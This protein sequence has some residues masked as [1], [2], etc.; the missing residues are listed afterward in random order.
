M[1]AWRIFRR[2]LAM[3][4]LLFSAYSI[5]N[6]AQNLLL[7]WP[8]Y[9]WALIGLVVFFVFSAFEVVSLDIELSSKRP[10][11]KLAREPFVG[12]V[13]RWKTV[14]FSISEKG[15]NTFIEKAVYTYATFVNRP[16]YGTEN[17][18]AKNV[19]ALITY[20][21][22]RGNILVETIKGRW[23]SS[24]HPKKLS[25]IEKLVY[26]DFPSD[27]IK[28]N[29]LDIGMKPFGDKA[30]YAYNNDSYFPPFNLFIHDKY[31][32]TEQK[33]D[34]KVE[35]VGERV[36]RPEYWFTVHNSDELVIRR[37]KK[38]IFYKRKKLPTT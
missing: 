29:Q 30:F 22:Q 36:P 20:Y 17:N 31:K 2:I 8:S 4:G 24:D 1:D 26:V 35:L 34:V 23:S 9:V 27:G 28:E 12:L 16:R 37:R 7:G 6:E 38:R 33:I 3:I 14:P 5:V 15:D 25:D 13:D 19:L 32:I 18:V 11:I 21:D 10:R